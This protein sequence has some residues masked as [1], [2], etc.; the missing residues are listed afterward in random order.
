MAESAPF[1]A[2]MRAGLGYLRR[3]VR[4]RPSGLDSS[5]GP[6]NVCQQVP[7]IWTFRGLVQLQ[8][9]HNM[10]QRRRTISTVRTD[11]F[12]KDAVRIALTSRLSCKQIAFDIGI[13][14]S[15]LKKWITGHRDTDVVWHYGREFALENI[16]LR[17]KNR[18]F[19]EERDIVKKIRP[20]PLPACAR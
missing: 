5:I 2:P 4:R 7:G 16:R 13:G 12:R 1:F 6:S 11:E 17:R 20:G 9:S 15:T 19:R 14:M 8:C 18:I 3:R 10:Q